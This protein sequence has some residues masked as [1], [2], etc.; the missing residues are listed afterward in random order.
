MPPPPPSARSSKRG[1]YGLMFMDYPGFAGLEER[2]LPIFYEE[3]MVRAAKVLKTYADVI[4]ETNSWGDAIFVV[5]TD[6]TS[7]AAA[8]L[9][10]CEQFA[11][12]DCDALGVPQGTAMRVALHYGPTYEGH[13]PVSARTTYYG[14]EV[15]RTAGIEPVTPSGSVYVT[16]PFA[17]ILEMEAP[18]RFVCNY[19]GKVSLAKG[20]GIFPLYGLTRSA[21]AH[22]RSHAVPAAGARAPET[23]PPIDRTGYL[24][25]A[26]FAW[27]MWSQVAAIC[28]V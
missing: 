2:V 25:D 13:D 16:E 4:Q 23:E 9:D 24:A 11:Q 1:T 7:A 19:V 17:A 21:A 26:T 8:A 6:A 3:V 14:T 20:Y 28:L 27:A 15:A 10:M 12:V 5:F 18:G 22:E